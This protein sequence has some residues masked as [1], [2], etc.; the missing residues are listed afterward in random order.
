MSNPYYTATGV[1]STRAAL[2]SAALRAEFALVEAGLSELFDS[3]GSILLGDLAGIGMWPDVTPGVNVHRVQDRL[4]VAAATAHTG[5]RTAPYGGTAITENVATWLEKNSQV[6]V[7]STN[8]KIG[9]LGWS[10]LSDAD[11]SGTSIAVAG[12]ARAKKAAGT[13]RAFYGDATLES[14]AAAVYG[15]E[16]AGTNRGANVTG[17]SYTLSG[18]TGV[19]F[20][21]HLTMEG[22]TGYT[23]GDSDTPVTVG[24]A[25]GTAAVNVGAGTGGGAVKRWNMGIRVV[26][27]GITGT[28]GVTGTG[29][30]IQLA[31]GH[32]INWMSGSAIQGAKIRSDVTAVA[33]QDVSLIFEPNAVTMKGTAE[34]ASIFR[35]QHTAS[36]VANLYVKNAATG[37]YPSLQAE[38]ESNTGINFLTNGTGSHRFYTGAS[39]SKEEFRVGGVSSAPD[40]FIHIYGQATGN[41]PLIKA[42]SAVD[43]N[44]DVAAAGKGTGGFRALDG[45]GAIKFAINT[46]GI[47]FFAT[48]PVAKQTGVAVS[49]AGIHAALVAYG[50]IS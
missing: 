3:D 34:T 21:A 11:T 28:D 43:S 7:G 38:G 29:Q 9:I 30:A 10:N 23:I 16:V 12:V 49:A 24:T 17:N 4:L 35:A 20:G 46:T 39:T 25:P 44:V 6:I 15:I 40:T 31:K 36:G 1:P 47:G 45:A 13:S 32:E 18:S 2:S 14:G 37:N 19:V 22:G 26:A 48:T 33:G 8:G 5:R 27:N 50:L 42:A 41:A